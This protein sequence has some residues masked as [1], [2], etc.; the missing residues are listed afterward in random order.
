MTGR[1]L[2]RVALVG[3]P[4]VGK[5][6]LFNAL[7]GVRRRTGNW[8][9]TTVEVASGTW[10]VAGGALEV[11][12][13]PGTYSLTA[14]SPDEALVR[15]LL[16]RSGDRQGPDLVVAVL[17]A[18]NLARNLYLLAQVLDVGV[19]V[20]VA[21]TMLDVAKARGRRVDADRLSRELGVPVVPLR[22][23]SGDGLDRL[24]A[25]VAAT[26]HTPP[27]APPA[28]GK[29]VETAV[30]ELAALLPAA[31]A[32]PGETAETGEPGRGGPAR[33]LAL[34]L[35]TE[36]EP[37]PGPG[38]VP[39]RAAV[40]SAA[41]AALRPRI[42]RLRAGIT[43]AHPDSPDSPDGAAATDGTDVD[44]IV[45]ER[46]YDWVRRVMAACVH[47]SAPHT[48]T[49]SD[50]LDRLVTSSWLGMPLF[51]AVMWGVFVATTELSAPLQDALGRV[52][53]GPVLDTARQLLGAAGLEGTWFATFVLGGLIP[54]VGAV[55]TFVPL[56]AIMF[57]LLSVLEGSGYLARAAFV[58]DRLLRLIGLPGRAFLPLIVG[59]G[60]NV[61]AIAATRVLPDARHRLLTG[62]LVPF[63][64]C[65]ARL[66]VYLL[67]ANVFFERH[68][69]TVVF[70]MYVLS[71][72][73]VLL[74]GVV[75]RRTL[76]RD[77]PREALI[78]EL[79]PYRLPAVRTVA[80][81]SWQRLAGFLRTAG[82]IIVAT[83]AAVWLLTA[84]PAGKGSFAQVPV[85]DSLYGRSSQAVSVV[86]EPAGF[87]DWHTTGALISG[88]VAK[89][90]VVSTFAQT[91]GTQE[92]ADAER[93]GDLGT[94]LTATFDEASGG[95]AVPAVLAFMVFLLAYTPCAATVAAQRAEFG[96][97]WALAGTGI[98]MAVAYALA[99]AVFQIGR[100]ML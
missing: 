32:G 35:L 87:G 81:E 92:P 3:N 37:A 4:N 41:A 24:A 34:R 53:D 90:A 28:L 29:G 27:P 1:A 63:V 84:I 75:L 19:P 11:L 76:F 73:L 57:V 65:S 82:G 89:E 59:F 86:F 18:A 33:H 98:Q 44:M 42:E 12:D 61:P 55:L 36:E 43:A 45:A 15:D 72:A 21:L 47:D 91:Y 7:T 51:L 70:A 97:R 95:H 10:P 23:R 99:V 74:V 20:V 2:A 49:L 46:R 66:T 22:P 16:A 79:P 31:K 25:E 93:A 78:L 88:F 39:A 54:G 64:T 58:A 48:W 30:R 85:A 100:L 60:C 5:S 38:P 52:A 17:D 9:G 13:L 68:A 6:T 80:G 40:L 67:L 94:R 83:T 14:R 96:G 71:I 62:I 77:Q 69:G 50:R 56:M 26:L 8:P